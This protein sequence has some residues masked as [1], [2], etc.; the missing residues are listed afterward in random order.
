MWMIHL[1]Y[2]NNTLKNDT[3]NGEGGGAS[4]RYMFLA[5]PINLYDTPEDKNVFRSS[6]KMI[7]D[8]NDDSFNSSTLND[9]FKD[10]LIPD[11]NLYSEL[12]YNYNATNGYQ[13][14]YNTSGIFSI[15]KDKLENTWDKFW[16]SLHN[17][18]LFDNKKKSEKGDKDDDKEEW[19]TAIITGWPLF[20]GIFMFIATLSKYN[21]SHLT[22]YFSDLYYKIDNCAKHQN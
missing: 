3:D 12:G 11:N 22:T 10:L 16:K 7:R 5:E 19:E 14:L 15:T 21:L 13:I 9:P 17:L 4:E 2:R 6:G 18:I 1:R 8:I 20:G